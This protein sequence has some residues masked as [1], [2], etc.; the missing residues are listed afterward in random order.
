LETGPIWSQLLL[1]VVL[2]A[3]N[4]FFASAELAILSVNENK[5]RMLADD[6]DKK[7]EQLL[8]M[9]EKPEGFL[10]TIQIG[11]TMAGF[12]ASAFAASSFA[13]P[14]VKWLV[15]DVGFTAVPASVLNTA[16]VILITLIL[17]FFTLV[18]GELVPKRVAM[19]KT[20]KMAKSAVSVISAIAKVVRPIVWLLSASTNGVLRLLGI[21]P[22]EEEESVTE[23]EIRMMVD[24]GQEE[25][26]IDE[27]EREMIENIFEFDNTS[28]AD[29]MTHRID[30]E[31]VWIE[32]TK[33]EIVSL[34]RRSGYSRFPVYDED[35]DD[36]IGVVNTRDYL[37]NLQAEHPKNLRQLMRPAFFVPESV[38][39]DDLFR[40]MQD[41]KIH[42]AVVVDEYGGTS[43]IVTL[44]DLL[45]EIVGNIYDES[46]PIEVSDIEQLEENLWR[47]AG[48]VELEALAEA[49]ELELPET[50]AF[51]TVGGLVFSQMINIPQDGTHPEVDVWGL[52]IYVEEITERRV[53]WTTISKLETEE[54]LP[55]A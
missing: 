12:L 29:V 26:A 22:E 3:L 6:G 1:Q 39:T 17:S 36:I 33:Q 16:S 43:G 50:D 25:G 35:I 30:V 15:E 49:L 46:D 34:I 9:R 18:F 23:E 55:E 47:V 52:H 24:I 13:E 53:E 2:I 41:E 42:F 21:N 28:A 27:D 11:I 20:E 38:R 48:S 14:L 51:D 45:E 32:D 31:A 5:L 7:A 40:N 8:K 10:S 54:E 44:E 37:L 4:A 19:K